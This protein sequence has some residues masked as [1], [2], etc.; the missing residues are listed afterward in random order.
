MNNYLYYR[1]NVDYPTDKYYRPS[2]CYPEYRYLA[3]GL[4]SEKNEIYDMIRQTFIELKLDADNIG[5]RKWNPLGEYIKDNDVVLVKPNLV[6]HINEKIGGKRGLECLITHPSVIRCIVDYAL[7]ALN[8]TGKIIVADAPVQACDFDKLK[9]VSGLNRVEEFYRKVGENIKIEDLRNYVSTRE[10]GV[11]KTKKTKSNFKG[12]IIN[13]GDKSY[14]YN[15]DKQGKL[16]I[17][18]YD[19]HEVNKHHSNEKQEYC[20]SEACLQADVIINVPKPK[21]HRKAGYTGALKNMV[22]INSAKDFL[23]HHTKGAY[24]TGKGDEYFYDSS[25]AKIR[26]DLFDVIDFLEKKKAYSISSFIRKVTGKIPND[27]EKY[28]EGSWWGNDTI[29]RTVLDINHIILFA[30]KKGK[31]QKKVQRKIITMGDLIIAGENEGPLLPTPK[32]TY[33]ILFAD[34]S[35]IFDEILVKFMGFSADKFK[36][37]KE[38]KRNSSVFGAYNEININSNLELFNKNINEFVSPYKFK[39]SYGWRDYLL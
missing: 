29:W 10:N 22:G 20:I 14:F 34:N 7:I 6:K 35:V 18:N 37:L 30:D 15:T 27:K 39:T 33:S 1:E 23:P 13:L 4:S 28:S 25:I 31:I 12:R 32:K 9:R 26:S 16:R 17:T 3:Q 2:D 24:Q 8:G 19:F 5:T 36:L 38:A 11:V 21:T